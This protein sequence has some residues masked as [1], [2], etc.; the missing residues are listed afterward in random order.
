MFV[1]GLY[2]YLRDQRIH[3]PWDTLLPRVQRVFD[4]YSVIEFIRGLVL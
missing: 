2:I 1:K 4:C 3:V